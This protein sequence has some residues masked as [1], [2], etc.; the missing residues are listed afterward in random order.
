MKY[1]HAVGFGVAVGLSLRNYCYLCHMNNNGSG[2][3][4]SIP[5]VTLNLLIINIGLWL[6][7]AVMP[8]FN[9]TILTHLGL[10][11]WGADDF[12]PLQFVTYMFLQAP[13]SQG[14]IAHIFFNMWAL[15]MFGRIL[16]MTWGTRRYLMFYMV[17]GVGAAIVQEIVWSFTWEKEYID[18]LAVLNKVTVREA[19]AYVDKGLAAGMPSLLQGMAQYKDMLITIGASG[20]IFGLLLGFGCVFPNVPMYIFFIPVP[21][22]AKWLVAGYAVLEFFF[23]MTGTLSSVAH[24]AHLGGMIFGGLLIL[25]WYYKGLLHGRRH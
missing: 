19:T 3:M 11:Y 20:A 10:H 18:A 13:L 6:L 17:C 1:F 23:G 15:Y 24:Y 21:V 8:S 14:G 5:P 2:F 12:N 22:K 25:Y 16:E 4:R 7:G 9:N